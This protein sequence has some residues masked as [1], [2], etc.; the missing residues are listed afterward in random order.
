MKDNGLGQNFPRPAEDGASP[1]QLCQKAVNSLIAD[2][3]RHSSY[4]YTLSIFL[5]EAGASQ[6]TVSVHCKI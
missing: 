1:S 2:H 5:P 3:L 4:N 6:E